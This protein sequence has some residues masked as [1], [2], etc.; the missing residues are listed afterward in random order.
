[1]R[2]LLLSCCLAGLVLVLACSEDAN[3][4]GLVN[5]TLTYEDI[6]D[7][8]RGTVDVWRVEG[9]AGHTSYTLRNVDIAII[10]DT[11]H[12]WLQLSQFS[13]S[14]DYQYY[15]RGF[16]LWD[17]YVPDVMVFELYEES[18]TQVFNPY[19]YTGEPGNPDSTE[20][21]NPGGGDITPPDTVKIVVGDNTKMEARFIS[22]MDLNENQMRLWDFI[23][24][25][26]LGD[27][28]LERN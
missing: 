8:W 20:A 12:Y 25:L 22:Y 17:P 24:Y 28:T 26:N 23:E 4:P 5:P 13:D 9:S 3:N 2:K 1:M 6:I 27:V 10:F 16:W 21:G 14:L 11:Q 7:S 18:S 19:Q 15:N